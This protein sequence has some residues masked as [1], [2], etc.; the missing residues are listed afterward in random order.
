MKTDWKKSLLI[1]EIVHDPNPVSAIVI[2]VTSSSCMYSIRI[3]VQTHLTS[4]KCSLVV[5]LFVCY[6]VDNNLRNGP[7]YM[8]PKESHKDIYYEG[9]KNYPNF[10]FCISISTHSEFSHTIDYN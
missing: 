5:F 7:I 3:L 8:D 1:D 9:R 10:H 2:G 4:I 6:T